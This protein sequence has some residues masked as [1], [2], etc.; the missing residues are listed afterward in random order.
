MWDRTG[1][2]CSGVGRI[3]PEM[4]RMVSFSYLSTNLTW[5]ERPHAGAVFGWTDT[6]LPR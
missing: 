4:M 3:V 6:L 2:H 5:E 1:S